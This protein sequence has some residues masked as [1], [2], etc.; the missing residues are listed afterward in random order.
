MTLTI[1]LSAEQETRLAA[2]ARQ[3]GLEPGDVLKKLVEEHL[4]PLVPLS[5]P[6]V[7][8]EREQARRVK[9]MHELT[10]ETERLGLYR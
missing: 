3:E 5:P 6:S 10:E 9:V 1:E 7:V 2:F 4:P 8:S